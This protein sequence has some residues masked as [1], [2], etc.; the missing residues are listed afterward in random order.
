MAIVKNPATIELGDIQGMVTRGY[1][2]L[3]ETAYIMLEITDA[4]KG[5]NWIKDILP[6]I[7]S[8]D[9]TIKRDKTLHLALGPNGL[10]SLGLKDKNINSFP[11]PFREGMST[12]HRNRILGDH[13]TNAP[14]NWRWGNGV[15]EDVLLVFH[16]T[17]KEAITSFL[18]EEKDRIT[19]NGGLKIVFETDGYLPDGNKEAFGFHDGISQ[20]VI[21]GSGKPGPDND[22]VE[23]G[24][25]LL[26]YKNEYGLYPDSPMLFE[27]QGDSSLLSDDPS[28]SGFKDLGKN[29]T[30]MVFRQMEQHVERFWNAMEKQT[31]NPDG[32]VNEKA[33]IRL[34]SK[35]VGRWPSGASL[36]NYPDG[37]PGGSH[38][39]DDF[40]YADTDPD[41]LKCP[42]GSHLRRNNPRDCFRFYDKKQSEKV[43]RRHRIIRRGKTYELPA[44]DGGKGEIGLQFICFNANIEMQFEFIQHAWSNDTQ[45]SGFSN[46]I[47]ILIGVQPEGNPE[48]KL[49]QF[50]IQNEPVNEF[51]DN[52]EQFVTIKG[53][54]YYFFP[55]LSFIKYLTTLGN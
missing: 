44:E 21:K 4:E 46:D 49:G 54:A 14:E 22:L 32:S 55:S 18:K 41:G 26:G 28:G 43:T 12:P 27:Q 40:G 45:S 6:M 42:Y 53:G 9:H 37:D 2:T 13:G 10:A 50:T 25:F 31:L 33:K 47:D 24:E 11:I 3:F 17:D 15:G 5:Q 19:A 52:W 23:T 20:P 35:C 16:A 8:A 36:V 30:Y 51:F 34:A 7:G 48:N 29:G 39:N 1:A 38:S